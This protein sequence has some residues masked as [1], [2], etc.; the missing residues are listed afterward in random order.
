MRL[1]IA[2][3]GMQRDRHLRHPQLLE[4]RLHD[5]L[6]RKLH[7][8]GVELQVEGSVAAEGPQ[9][10]VGIAHPR[11]EKEIEDPREHRIA[12]VAVHRRHRPG[13]DLPSE[14]VAHA[15]VVALLQLRHHRHTLAK[16]VGGVAIAHH[17]EATAGL[18]DPVDER[19]PIAPL[20]AEGH[21]AAPRLGILAATV[22]AAIVGDQDLGREPAGG[23][24]RDRLLGRV[25]AGWQRDP[26]IQTRHEDRDVD[27]G[28]NH[29]ADRVSGTGGWNGHRADSCDGA[30]CR[31]HAEPRSSACVIRA[32]MP[33]AL[34]ISMIATVSLSKPV[35]TKMNGPRSKNG[36]LRIR[37]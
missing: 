18:L 9:A 7:A 31:I 26:L 11:M 22:G 19:G 12:Q 6:A 2:A 17:D 21:P 35:L 30:G 36:S 25:D 4:G 5:Q 23:E 16:I 28:V 24:R 14:T 33:A 3:V 29:D 27:R 32:C 13:H 34:A 20:W 1:A 10:A 15:E 8:R 37:S